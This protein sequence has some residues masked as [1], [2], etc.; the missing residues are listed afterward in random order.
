MRIRKYKKIDLGL[1]YEKDNSNDNNASGSI[2]IIGN[3][4]NGNRK[5]E[6]DFK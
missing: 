6:Y 4:P 1:V 3:S 5:I 2:G